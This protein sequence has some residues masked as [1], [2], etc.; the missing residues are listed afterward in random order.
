MAEAGGA[1]V[2]VRNLAV[3]PARIAEDIADLAAITEPDHR[4]TRRSFTPMF[5]AGRE[6]LIRRFEAA[7]LE[8]WIDPAGNLIGRRA[9]AD[10]AVRGGARFLR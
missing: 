5:L 10:R 9:G 3:T 2:T 4:W 6:Y 8:T 7:G 1:A